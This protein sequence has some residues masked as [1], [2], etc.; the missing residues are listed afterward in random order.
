MKCG[1]ETIPATGTAT[2]VAASPR[3]QG[4]GALRGRRP[5]RG[6]YSGFALGLPMVG[7]KILS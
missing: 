4:L 1:Y 7:A 2:T 5:L 6:G 3:S